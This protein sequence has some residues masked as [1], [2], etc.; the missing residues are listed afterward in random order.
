MPL[1]WEK[2][3]DW[4][5]NRWWAD[6]Q[7][8][9]VTKTKHFFNKKEMSFKNLQRQCFKCSFWDVS[10]FVLQWAAT[11]HLTEPAEFYHWIPKYAKFKTLHNLSRTHTDMV[12]FSPLLPKKVLLIQ[13]NAIPISVSFTS[14]LS[15]FITSFH[16]VYTT[17]P[18]IDYKHWFN[19]PKYETSQC[20]MFP[21][22]HNS[23]TSPKI[24]YW[25]IKDFNDTPYLKSITDS[26]S[27]LHRRSQI[28]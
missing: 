18:K 20:S 15:K 3:C 8:G 5:V 23:N 12:S 1:Q 25:M 7:R 2:F 26:P 21:S 14:I 28:C 22:H 4:L 24:S 16:V 19:V 13:F 6:F 9:G 11:W 10:Y 17:A 27:T